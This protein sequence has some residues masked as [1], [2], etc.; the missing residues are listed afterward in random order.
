MKRLRKTVLLLTVLLLALTAC[1]KRTTVNL[2]EL[3]TASITEEEEETT[4]ASTTVP[5]TE[6]TAPT[7]EAPVQTTETSAQ[8]TEA[9]PETT[10]APT[11]EEKTEKAYILN[12][13]SK[14]IHDP[15]C[16][17]VQKMKPSNKKEYMGSLEDLLQQ[18]YVPCKMCKPE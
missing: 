1:D 3:E 6:E 4:E 15:T 9:P 11:V 10:E 5:V 16:E 8:T 14:K 7:T 12:I 18:G 2:A 17:S 13:N